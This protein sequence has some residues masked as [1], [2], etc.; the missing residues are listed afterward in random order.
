MKI[1]KNTTN[2]IWASML[3]GAIV[4]FI[5]LASSTS[6]KVNSTLGNVQT[7]TQRIVA[8]EVQMKD[9]AEMKSDIKQILAT[10]NQM[11]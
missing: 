1:D 4:I 7:N 2:T 6:G 9:L 10:L 8:L 3:T 11:K 5:F